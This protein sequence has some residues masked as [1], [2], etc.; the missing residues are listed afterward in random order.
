MSKRLVKKKQKV[1]IPEI[2]EPVLSRRHEGVIVALLSNPTIK[3]AATAANVSESTVWRL[4][5]REDFQKRY[6]EAQDKAVDGALGALQGAATQ[7]IESLRKNL[8]CGT[9]AAEVQAA[10]AILDFTFKAREQFDHA[11]RLKQLESAL[12]AREEADRLRGEKGDED[13]D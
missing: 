13:E 3:D 9:P 6:K 7:A 12:K 5:Q 11:T 8:S 10:K 1:I 4:M 2:V